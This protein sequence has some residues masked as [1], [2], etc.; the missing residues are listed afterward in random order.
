MNAGSPNQIRDPFGGPAQVGE[1]YANMLDWLAT[2]TAIIIRP[3]S[4]Y[5]LPGID[6]KCPQPDQVASIGSAYSLADGRL[7]LE[8]CCAP[9]QPSAGELPH[10][11]C[12]PLT[13][14]A[15]DS[16]HRSNTYI[17][18]RANPEVAGNVVVN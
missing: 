18:R 6:G 9:S 16:T 1:G 13:F 5:M 7:C 12:T 14:H 4:A 3:F 15:I 10:W 11:T 17:V 2:P 8:G